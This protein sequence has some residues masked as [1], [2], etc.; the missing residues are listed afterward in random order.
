MPYRICNYY[1]LGV[2]DDDRYYMKNTIFDTKEAAEEKAKEMARKLALRSARTSFFLNGC[3]IGI[4]DK[5]INEMAE[6][7]YPREYEKFSV[8][9]IRTDD[10]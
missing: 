8:R 6:Q 1:Y 9:K 5:E 10:K 2:T 7:F 3:E 4:T